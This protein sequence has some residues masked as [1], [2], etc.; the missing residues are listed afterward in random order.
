MYD[1]VVTAVDVING[2][3]TVEQAGIT[4]DYKFDLVIGADG[5]GSI[6]RREMESQ[7]EEFTT[8]YDEIP[9]YSTMLELDQNTDHMDEKYLYIYTIIHFASLGR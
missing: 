3:V 5:G 4:D 9:N 2:V 1:S 7:L 8:E 6:V